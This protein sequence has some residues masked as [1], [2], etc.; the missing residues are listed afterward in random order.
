[1]EHSSDAW[2][3][4]KELP[5]GDMAWGQLKVGLLVLICSCGL[6]FPVFGA[7]DPKPPSGPAPA[8]AAAEGKPAQVLQVDLQKCLDLAMENNH[9]R[10]ASQAALEAAEAQHQQALSSFWPQVNGRS[11][12]TILKNNPNFIFPAETIPVPGQIITIPANAFGPGFPP[13]PIPLNTPA[14]R[15]VVP[16]QNVKLMDRRLL[17][18]SLNVDLP[19]FTGGLRYA[20]VKQAKCGVEA[21]RQD[22]R[23]TDLQVAYDVNRIRG[24]PG[25]S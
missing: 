22:V 14:G 17:T 10:P 1:L 11:A 9:N 23:R 5:E 25:R 4:K 24:S 7:D 21:A 18:S 15:F 12:Y 20:K 16:Q 6:V 3:E 19:L 2:E 13:A 8:A